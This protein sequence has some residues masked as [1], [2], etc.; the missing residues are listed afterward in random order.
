MKQVIAI[1]TAK[2]ANIEADI[3]AFDQVIKCHETDGMTEKRRE[4]R[5][6]SEEIEGAIRM[7]KCE[8]EIKLLEHLIDEGRIKDPND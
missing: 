1:L 6:L 3:A 7:L 2:Q 4:L 8:K 5:I